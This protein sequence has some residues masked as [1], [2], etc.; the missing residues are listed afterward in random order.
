MNAAAMMVIWPLDCG[1]MGG[2]MDI[3]RDFVICSILLNLM[4]LQD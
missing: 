1:V 2:C 3:V 4:R